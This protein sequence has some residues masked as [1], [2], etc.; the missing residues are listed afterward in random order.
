MTSIL[1]L[2][3]SAVIG[4]GGP[5]TGVSIHSAASHTE[6]VVSIDGHVE[7]QDFMLAG[8]HRLVLDLMGARHAMEQ[9]SYTDVNRGGIRAIRTSQYSDDIVR[10]VLELDESVP[11]AVSNQ[12]GAVLIRLENRGGPFESWSA[13]GR[14]GVPAPAETPDLTG[15][16][17]V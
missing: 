3:L 6:V 8:P 15:A 2:A 13:A 1:T 14:T 10:L 9:E 11:Y 7:V 4:V 16:A 17:P 12:Q 5:V